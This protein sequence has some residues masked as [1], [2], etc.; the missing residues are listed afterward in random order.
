MICPF[1]DDILRQN[2]QKCSSHLFF[3]KQNIYRCHIV[4]AFYLLQVYYKNRRSGK[5][6]DKNL[7]ETVPNPDSLEQ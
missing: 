6:V 3:P 2:T 1:L 7:S 5:T 4:R